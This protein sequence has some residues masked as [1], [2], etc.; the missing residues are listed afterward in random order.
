MG[1]DLRMSVPVVPCRNQGVLPKNVRI[2]HLHVQAATT[3][4]VVS[5]VAEGWRTGHGGIIVTPNLDIFLRTREDDD[6][7][8]TVEQCDLAV[9]DGMPLVWA[10]RLSGQP[11]PERVTGASLVEVL[12]EAAARQDRSLFIVGGGSSDTSHRAAEALAARH[13]G[14][15]VVGAVTPPFGFDDNPDKIRELSEQVVASQA[16]LVFVGLGF[17]K[18]ERLSL[19]LR[20]AMPAT[21]FLG[22]GAGIQ[23]AAGTVSRAPLWVQR[24]GAEWLARLLQEPKRLARRYLRDDLPV[25][26][27][28]LF[29]SA[30]AGL[31][32]WCEGRG[33]NARLLNS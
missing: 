19:R 20:E 3:N 24:I 26:V 12:A 30:V 25:A 2:G 27:R 28:L 18:Q 33:G 4:D 29:A 10:A 21:W 13:R 1:N 5:R 32:K 22:C 7:L 23:M 9:A 14:L 16:D 17:P 15:R 31:R 11:L 6:A 8:D